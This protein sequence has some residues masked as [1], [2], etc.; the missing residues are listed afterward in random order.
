MDVTSD[1]VYCRMHG[2][3]EL[4]ASGYG[5]A[6]LDQ[7]AERVVAWARGAEPTDAEKVTP[8]P[9]TQDHGRDVYVYFDN[10]LKVRAPF[11]AQNMM[12]RVNKLLS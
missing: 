1:F 4:Y 2:S 3:E 9:S 7:W 12:Q 11:D 10:D 8:M 5:D 6:S